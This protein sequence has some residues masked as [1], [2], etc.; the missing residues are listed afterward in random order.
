MTA[1]HFKAKPKVK[2]PYHL[3]MLE[4][5]KTALAKESLGNVQCM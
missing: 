5:L 1:Q 2:A 3:K 4:K